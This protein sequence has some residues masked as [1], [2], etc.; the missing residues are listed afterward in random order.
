MK[1]QEAQRLIKQTFENPF[2]KTQFIHFINNLLKD[3][4][5]EKSFIQ[6]GAHLPDAFSTYI[7]KM[8]R[9]GKYE[10]ATGNF[11]DILMVELKRDH[12]IEYARTAQRNFIRRYLN[13]SRGGEL[14]D[15][16]IVAFY[17][18]GSEDWRFSLIKM[19][20]SLEKKKDELTPAKRF[21][22]LVGKNE[23]SHTAQKQLAG[24]LTMDKVPLLEDIEK[25]FNIEIVTIEFFDKYKEL[26][27]HVSDF[28][29][30]QLEKNRELR[31]ELTAKNI[32]HIS[33]TKKL[34]GQ[35]VF[36]YFLQKKGWLGV[37]KS[38]KWGEGDKKFLR[39]L[40][41]K[42]TSA[43]KNY[44]TDYLQYL[45]Y[46]AL[47][48][49]RRNAADPSYY[50]L[51][52]CKI[53]F[54]NGG[55]FEADYD[56]ENITVKIPN[57]FFTNENITKEGDTGDGI[58]DVFDRY[59]FT[60]KEDEPLEKEV[61]V[62]PEM[63]GKVFEKLLEVKD[64]KSK[65][66]FYTPREIVHYMCQESLINYL[67]T[68]LNN[69]PAA[70]QKLGTAQ[71][72]MFGNKVR[73]GQLALEAEFGATIKVPKQDLEKFIREGNSAIDNDARVEK[74]G[75][76][77]VRYSYH[78][79]ESIR[80]YAAD[81]D[82]ALAGIRVCDPAIGSGAFPVGIMNE[83]VK[84]REILTTYL[85]AKKQKERTAYEF[86]RHCIQESIYGVDIDHSAIDIAKLR[87]WLSLV[88]DEQDLS[89]VKPLPNLDYKI[90][91]GNSLIGMPE[92]SFRNAKLEDEIQVLKEE[93]F[94]ETNKPTK[95]KLREKINKK[96]R[97]LLDSA[98]QF[99]GYKID[100][101]FK[102]FFSEV[103]HEKKGFDM[104]IGNPPY[105]DI[106]KL[107]PLEVR[108]YFK[109]FKTCQNRINLYSIFIEKGYGL[110]NTNG[111]LVF[112]NP[113]SILINESYK[114]IRALI[115]DSVS[116]IIK[117]PD[118]IFEKAIVE[119]IILLLSK[120]SN[121]DTIQGKYYHNNDSVNFANIVFNLYKRKDWLEDPE[122][123][124]NIFTDDVNGKI[125]KKIELNADSLDKYADFSLGITPYDKYQGHSESLIKNRKFHSE[126]KLTADYVPLISGKNIH[127]YFITNE[128]DEYLRYGKWLGAPREKR[129]FIN[130]KIIVRQIISG[131][132]LRIY[133]GYSEMPRYFTQIGFSIISKS[134]NKEE[135][136]F[137]LAILNSLLM[138]FY[139]GNKF[140]DLEKILFQKILIGNCKKF[141]IAKP[142]TI[143]P[144]ITLVDKI[145][146]A[147]KSDPAANT[148]RW[149]KQIDIMVYH[150]YNLTYEEAKII[151]PELSEAEFE[152][153]K[154]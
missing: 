135:L 111:T 45:F 83:I 10:D 112:I 69:E 98:E 56:W 80:T 18:E 96:I 136:K 43:K 149:E 40:L 1:S 151:E 35:I 81:I 11:I 19:Q 49:E 126:K 77:T 15:A 90:V 66:A 37:D 120:G 95:D 110:I 25:A 100:F 89:T 20:Y 82:K 154:L 48:E 146:E 8:E 38:G 26:F 107:P 140:L 99:A 145:L 109:E 150:L 88:V 63:L 114:K 70:Y 2:N 122:L 3:E 137:I 131:T 55:L 76:E 84:A 32:D 41:E 61:A 108:Y 6:T 50:R 12:S 130:P 144:F 44:Y 72:D 46:E 97:Q 132:P 54:L 129:F 74:A 5:Q 125:I 103:F 27:L 153:Y 128:I 102:L 119:T 68:A 53:P 58:L 79:P 101:D 60:V 78:L 134:N 36:L 7:R 143:K 116:L 71:T 64:R 23:R 52:D 127:R 139:H 39:S 124:F 115:F 62:D 105:V 67:D 106:K 31:N 65:G 92:G 13:G 152:K 33:F 9:I 87:L 148:S 94:N 34:L 121:K 47:A 117:L 138:N 118:A 91:W 85:P 17:T 16:A 104:V 141:P 57:E 147:K 75:R 42:A 30:K 142:K 51:L 123:R 28:F 59:N 29:E 4:Y 73:K 113:N 86:K 14:K 22:F 21:S 133:A 24:L 93:L